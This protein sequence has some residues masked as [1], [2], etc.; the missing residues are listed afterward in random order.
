MQVESTC[1]REM[2]CR[3]V[4]GNLIKLAGLL[5][6]VATSAGA[7]TEAA[8]VGDFEQHFRTTIMEEQIPG[9][10]FAVVSGGRIVWIATFGHTDLTL[11]RP[12]DEQTVFRLASV[13][14]GFAATVA[15]L[16]VR[17]GRLHWNEP[18]NR[19][20]PDLRFQ[21]SPDAITIHDILGQSTGFV[22]HAFDNLI[23]DGLS[24]DA[25]MRR[26]EE[27]APICAPG[28]CY[29]YQ[30]SV[31]SLIEPVIE[32]VGDA[33]Y[34]DVLHERIFRPLMMETAS[35]GFDAYLQNSNRAEPHVKRHQSWRTAAVRPNYYQINSAAG[36]NAS[37]LDMARWLIAQLGHHPEVIPPDVIEDVTTPRIRTIRDLNRRFWR[38]H[39]SDAH[40]GLGWRIYRFGDDVL[41][42]HG[43]WVSGYRAEAAFSR[44]LDLGLVLLFNAESN[45]IS[46]LHARFWMQAFNYLRQPAV[47]E[48]AAAG[49]AA[50][51][52]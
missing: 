14:K 37:V 23:E 35:V 17:D 32:S 33:A 8:L 44:E 24:R 48:T 29:T 18:V 40:Y 28:T 12:V 46:E 36:V 31:F 20:V 22:S 42:Y 5:I 2:R 27:L 11:S 34:A 21:G 50:S 52:R 47:A 4:T 51:S 41:V 43:G 1:S 38:E 6:A 9:A 39:L 7:Q 13:S 19:Y 49:S 26:F 45:V 15:A 16:L 30:N 3:E 10:A 25:I